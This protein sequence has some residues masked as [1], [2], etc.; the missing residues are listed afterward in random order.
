MKTVFDYINYYKNKDYDECPFNDM[1]NII[2]SIIAYLPLDNIE[3]PSITI[4]EISK[5]LGQKQTN[6]RSMKKVALKV[7]E[8]IKDSPRYSNIIISKYISILGETQFSAMTIRYKE[9]ECYVAYRGTDNSLIGWRENLELGYKYPT[10]CQKYA[11]DYLKNTITPK[12]K[13]IYVGGHSKGGNLAMTAAMETTNTIFN[14]IKTIYNNDGPGFKKEEYN[15]EKYNKMQTKLKTFI[16]EESMVGVLLLSN[17]KYTI[18]KSKDHG[19]YQH[20]PS[21]W[22]CFGQFLEPGKL[23]KYSKKIQKQINDY[24]KETADENKKLMVDTL[25][26]VLEKQNIKYFYEVK[27]IS[28]KEFSDLIKDVKGVDEKS[29]EVIIQML[30][31]LL[32]N[33]AKNN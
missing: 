16:P 20:Y 4:N 5:I 13:I 10:N 29:K 33:E 9:K 27:N 14:K 32:F 31:G 17:E 25:F 15:S 30:K 23:S 21:N 8:N 12:D 19:P 22:L 28:F 24:I 2:F 6:I 18:V 26:D 11:I 3:K 7:L 1:D